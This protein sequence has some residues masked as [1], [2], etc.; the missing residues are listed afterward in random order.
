[1]PEQTVIFSLVVF[2]LS[3]INAEKTVAIIQ[4][5]QSFNRCAPFK[6]FLMIQLQ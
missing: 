1:M 2:G 6:N 3:L 5:F 4:R